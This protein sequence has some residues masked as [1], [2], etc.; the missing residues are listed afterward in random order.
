MAQKELNY[1][2]AMDRARSGVQTVQVELGPD[3]KG[4]L[5]SA[6][7][8]TI[9]HIRFAKDVIAH[10]EGRRYRFGQLNRDGSFELQPDGWSYPPATLS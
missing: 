2:S 7:D 10:N 1:T 4:T 9:F 3:L 5:V 6:S 8:E